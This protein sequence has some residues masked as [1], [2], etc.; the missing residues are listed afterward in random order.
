MVVLVV[1]DEALVS[2]V[3]AMVLRLAGYHVSGPTGSVQRALELAAAE[4][5]DVAFL[6]INLDGGAEGLAL[7]RTLH[8]RYGTTCIFLTAQPQQALPAR[9]VALGV[10]TKPY[11]PNGIAN[12]L[13][14]AAALRMGSQLPATPRVSRG[15]LSLTF[16]QSTVIVGCSGSLTGLATALGLDGGEPSA[17]PEAGGLRNQ[18]RLLTAGFGR[19]SSAGFAGESICATEPHAHDRIFLQP[20]IF[21]LSFLLTCA[22]LRLPPERAVHASDRVFGRGRPV[23]TRKSW[24]LPLS[25]RAAAH[26]RPERP[27]TWP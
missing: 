13:E 3:L 12:V 19:A 16:N 23:P 17:G 26:H 27:R 8:E 10:I 7:A 11:D 24:S 4:R 5:P 20:G 15:L 25:P 9:D 1:E 18:A 6:D 22:G 21:H 14:F 2:M